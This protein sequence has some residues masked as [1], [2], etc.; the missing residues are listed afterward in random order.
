M[1][2]YKMIFLRFRNVVWYPQRNINSSRF[3]GLI[4]L[5]MVS[6]LRLVKWATSHYNVVNTVIENFPS[7]YAMECTCNTL[8]MLLQWTCNVLAMHLE[9][10]FNALVMHLQ[11]TCNALVMLS[12]K[13]RRVCKHW[14]RKKERRERHFVMHLGKLLFSYF[15]RVIKYKG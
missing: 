3:Q 7:M 8:A 6:V 1:K 14:R 15:Y 2:E 5:K 4:C 12:K 11:C 13:K 10:A 9:C